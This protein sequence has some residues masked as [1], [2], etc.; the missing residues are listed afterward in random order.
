MLESYEPQ[1]RNYH[2]IKVTFAHADYFGHVVFKVGG[3]CKGASILA[4]G[5]D[6]WENCDEE[7]IE[8]LVQNDCELSLYGNNYD[9]YWFKVNLTNPSTG[10][11]MCIEELDYEDLADMIIAVE[12]VK[13]EP[14]K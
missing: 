10:D 8:N 5:L 9:E 3:N 6:F 4:N 1:S 11:Q 2:H 12:I 14:E 7:D 13:V